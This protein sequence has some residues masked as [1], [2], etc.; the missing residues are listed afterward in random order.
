MTVSGNLI[1]DAFALLTGA[2]PATLSEDVTA[3]GNPSPPGVLAHIAL[4]FPGTPSQ[5]VTFMHPQLV[6]LP[7][8]QSTGAAGEASQSFDGFSLVPGS[9]RRRRPA[10]PTAGAAPFGRETP[11]LAQQGPRTGI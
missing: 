11:S 1:G 6:V 8:I 3:N 10:G 7:R 5:T 4:S 9:N 2:P